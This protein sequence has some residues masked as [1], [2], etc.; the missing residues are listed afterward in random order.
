M[1]NKSLFL[2]ITN[3]RI[4]D[5]IQS[6]INALSPLGGSKYQMIDAHVHAVNFVQETPGLKNLL[7]QMDKSNIQKAVVFGLPVT[8]Q[9]SEYEREAPEYYLDDDSECYYY[10]LTD[11]IVAEEYKKLNPK[12]QKRLYPLICGF[13]PADRHAIKHIER[14]YALYPGVFRGIG[15]IFLR[16][17]D[18]T[19]LTSGDVPRINTKSLYPIFEFAVSHDLPVLV[20]N[21]ISTTWIA[22]RP[23]YLHE[24]EEILRE[25]PRA[26]IVFCHCG[27]S[28]R[29]YA[30]F[31]KKMIERL[32][33][34]YP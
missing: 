15:E 3:E 16:H 29:V 23:K 4:E 25:F 21:N 2:G 13:N 1:L 10:S 27:I 24:L 34:Q 9:W 7:L 11:T 26:K 33:L 6:G 5:I 17:D 19:L 32:L 8:K 20:H 14:M 28:R 22:D 12:Q 18:L 30:P 31:Y